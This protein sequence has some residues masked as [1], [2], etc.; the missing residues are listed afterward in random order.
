MKSLA[1]TTA[2]MDKTTAQL[3]DQENPITPRMG[4][5]LI[6]QWIA[7]LSEGENTRPI[8][9]ELQKLKELLQADPLEAGSVVG[10]MGLVATKVL[11]IAPDMGA[12]GE[13]PSLLNALSAALRLSPESL[14]DK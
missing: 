8:A 6:D 1:D 11:S 13:M 5:D 12:E 10:Q 4:I 14:E 7:P 2:L 3:M 9:E